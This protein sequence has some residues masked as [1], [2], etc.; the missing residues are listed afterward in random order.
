[1]TNH[2]GTD[3]TTTEIGLLPEGWE[4]HKIEELFDIFVGGDVNKINLS[5]IKSNT[6]K[7]PIFSNSLKEKG[8]FGYSDTYQFEPGCITITARGEVGKAEF[9]EEP[10]SA[11][12][13]LLVLK[14]KS[15]ISCYFVACYINSFLNFSHVGSAV[16]QLTA[17]AI[18]DIVIAVPPFSEQQSIAKILSGLDSKIDLNQGMNKTLESIAQALF[19]HW[20]IDFEFPDENGQPYKSSGGEMVVSEKGLIPEGWYIK[21]LVSI[22]TLLKDGTHFP[23]KR[24]SEGVKFIAGATDVKHFSVDFSKCTYIT[25]VDYCKIHK[26]WKLQ[27]NDILL[28]IV[29]TVGNVA[30]VDRDDLPFSMQ[31][32]I[33]VLRPNDLANYV[34]LYLLVSSTSFR[35][36]IFKRVNPTA[37]PGIYLNGLSEISVMVPP[38]YVLD[39]FVAIVEPVIKKIR[40]NVKQN[41]TISRI[42]D[43]LLPQL[44]SGKIRVPMEENDV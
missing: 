2:I 38:K 39:N 13:R 14:P 32:S 33:A 35:D 30:I 23:P 20:F 12:V 29:G 3:F 6:F 16:N 21:N 27:E 43:G 9:R 19:K 15:E 36:E 7:Y 17:P 25:Q 4:T 5:K 26:N 28:T 40:V 44:I 10:F 31:R 18:S 34:Y 42:R 24:V 22:L 41:M 8:L 11:I 1:M 37:Q